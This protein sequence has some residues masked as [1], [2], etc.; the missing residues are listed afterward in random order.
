MT[1]ISGTLYCMTIRYVPFS[2][3]TTCCEGGS[4]RMSV[5]DKSVLLRVSKTRPEIDV[6]M[7]SGSDGGAQLNTVMRRK[8]VRHQRSIRIGL[9][10]PQARSRSVDQESESGRH[11]RLGIRHLSHSVAHSSIGTRVD[12]TPS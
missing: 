2:S 4:V 11:I 7:G 5:P 8:G 1:V 3:D 9:I 12:S 6:M 10:I